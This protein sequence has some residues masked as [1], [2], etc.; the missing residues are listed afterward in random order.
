[1]ISVNVNDSRREN[2]ALLSS[3]ERVTRQAVQVLQAAQEGLSVKAVMELQRMEQ[4]Q[5][6]VGSPWTRRDLLY[7]AGSVPSA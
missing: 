4:A 2:V 1:M 5:R 3:H 6:L 7:M